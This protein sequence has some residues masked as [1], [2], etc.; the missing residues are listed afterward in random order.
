MTE[1]EKQQSNQL[2][3]EIAQEEERI[4][5]CEAEL[6]NDHFL[7]QFLVAGGRPS[8][9]EL[10]T[11]LRRFTF[12]KANK[13]TPNHYVFS[14][15]FPE[16]S[17]LSAEIDV[18]D[19]GERASVYAV[20]CRLVWESTYFDWLNFETSSTRTLHYSLN[21]WIER[22]ADYLD[23]D[24]QRR[25][26]DVAYPQVETQHEQAFTVIQIPIVPQKTPAEASAAAAAAAVAP[27][28]E[29]EKKQESTDSLVVTWQ[30]G[31]ILRLAEAHPGL[32]QTDLDQ[33]VVTCNND[34]DQ[35]LD[36]LVTQCTGT[37]KEQEILDEKYRYSP[38]GRKRSDYEVL[39][40][41]RME[42]NE[43]VLMQLGLGGAT[44]EVIDPR[45]GVIADMSPAAIA[46][47]AMAQSAEGG[48][49]KA[50][51]KKPRT[52]KAKKPKT[53]GKKAA[54]KGKA[55]KEEEKQGEAPSA[56]APEATPA[57]ATEPAPVAAK[58]PPE[59]V[60]DPLPEE[61]KEEEEQT[62]RPPRKRSK[63]PPSETQPKAKKRATSP[64]ETNA[65]EAKTP[66]SQKKDGRMT[67]RT[68]GRRLPK[69]SDAQESSGKEDE[70]N[71]GTKRSAAD[72][73]AAS[74]SPKRATR[75]NNKK[76]RG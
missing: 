47:A 42:R 23:F 3:K 61:S 10:Q 32:A 16:Y 37:F 4:R 50:A 75:G 59:A 39:R 72:E 33:L 20:R 2:R 1:T 7:R 14:G 68:S 45:T 54:A 69:A 15:F 6:A 56:S 65:E 30:F 62:K 31:G 63:D 19:L 55:T 76:A 27:A 22:V 67:L 74:A 44:G 49:K 66:E 26:L 71:G 60:P 36:L 21:V 8:H 12:T 53:P 28:K 41:S 52:P 48:K 57:A 13:P 34:V 5:K 58:A 17:V 29:E 9:P 18:A 11:A 35:A 51:P 25:R 24:R 73:E 40:C 64:K 43:T 38:T 46:E 70:A